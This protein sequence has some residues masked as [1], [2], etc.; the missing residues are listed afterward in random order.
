MKI[1]SI[2][3][4]FIAPQR[5]RLI[6][7][8]FDLTK[9]TMLQDKSEESC[10]PGILLYLFKAVIEAVGESRPPALLFW[11]TCLKDK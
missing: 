6:R 1:I 10:L 7:G 11:S 8:A 3:V 4:I 5:E 2:V 9:E